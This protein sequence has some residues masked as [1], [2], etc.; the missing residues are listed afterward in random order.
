[1]SEIQIPEIPEINVPEILEIPAA[2]VVPPAINLQ[3]GFPI[4]D[5]PCAETRERQTSGKE[6]FNNDPDGNTVLCDHAPAWYFAPDYS[7]GARV[8]KKQAPRTAEQPEQKQS[9]NTAKQEI[10]KNE[11][12]GNE[13]KVCPDPNENNPRIGDIAASGKEKV[14]GFELR[15]E[16]CVVLY[17]PVGI[18]KYVPQ[19]STVSTT[20]I[21]ASTAVVSSVL[22]KPLA[23][24][25]LKI[26]K[27]SVKKIITTLKTKILKKEP[28]R[29]SLFQKKREQSERNKA[30]RKL[31][32]GW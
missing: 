31:K 19:I 8:V 4:I 26:I 10:P 20:S 2:I 16:I 32:K 22:A 14:S 7:P 9:T 27:P 6:H 5:M 13:E 23:D 24:L 12:E 25:M 17:E 30:F 15:G 3:Q 21:I 18:E 28:E 1:M 29:K 11:N